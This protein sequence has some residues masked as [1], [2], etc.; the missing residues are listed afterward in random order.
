MVQPWLSI[1]SGSENIL[2]IY[3][4]LI[5]CRDAGGEK[6]ENLCESISRNLNGRFIYIGGKET[7]GKGLVKLYTVPAPAA[8]Q[9]AQHGK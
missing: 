5:L 2:H 8:G 1:L 9:V 7:I 3:I 6:A 4:S